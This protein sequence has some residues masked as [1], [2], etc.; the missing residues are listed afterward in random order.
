M[1]GSRERPA[2]AVKGL[3]APLRAVAAVAAAALGSSARPA[4]PVHHKA[5]KHSPTASGTKRGKPP[6][7]SDGRRLLGVAALLAL[8]ALVAAAAAAG[9]VGWYAASIL[10]ER[11]EALAAAAA[12]VQAAVSSAAAVAAASPEHE[13]SQLLAG[14]Y[15]VVVMSC[16]LAGHAAS[17]VSLA[18][19]CMCDLPKNCRA[20]RTLTD[21]FSSSLQST[22]RHQA[23]VHHPSVR[24]QPPG[25][26]PLGCA[27]AAARHA[28]LACLPAYPPSPVPIC[29]HCSL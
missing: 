23:A 11:P 27:H 1:G 13:G 14:N 19:A 26:L 22:C 29:R 15:T 24:R 4:L 20:G 7:A 21:S 28:V 16:E 9:A 5:A 2:G 10:H 6:R 25:Q 3:S 17:S 12:A 18:W 8:A